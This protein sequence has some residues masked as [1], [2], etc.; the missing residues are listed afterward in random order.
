MAGDKVK[1][2]FEAQSDAETYL[3]EM[4]RKYDLSDRDKALR[5]LLDYAIQDGNSDEIFGE[6]RCLRC[7]D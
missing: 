6:I 2:A 5:C 7:E 3:D 1:I 4:V